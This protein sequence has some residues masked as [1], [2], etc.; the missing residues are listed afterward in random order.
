M[1]IR[2]AFGYNYK[3]ASTKLKSIF[4]RNFLGVIIP[5]SAKFDYKCEKN[6]TFSNIFQ[7]EKSNFW[8]ISIILQLLPIKFETLKPPSVQLVLLIAL[9]LNEPL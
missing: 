5:L 9:L 7:K 2:I 6:Y 8:R 4:V 1:K 3:S